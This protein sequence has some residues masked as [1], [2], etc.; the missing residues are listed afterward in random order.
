MWKK[1]DE[2]LAAQKAPEDAPVIMSHTVMGVPSLDSTQMAVQSILRQVEGLKSKINPAEIEKID[3]FIGS[4]LEGWPGLMNPREAEAFMNA[5]KTGTRASTMVQAFDKIGPQ[6]GGL[7]NVGAARFALMEPRLISA[8]QL[9]SGFSLGQL[10]RNL[11]G[12]MK[13][14]HETY[15]KS[16]PGSYIGGFRYQV[17]AE[18]MFPDWWK[19]GKAIDKNGNPVTLTNRQQALMTQMPVQKANQEWLDNIMNHFEQNKNKWG[20]Y[21]GGVTW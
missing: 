5:D 13:L 3:N 17:P 16:F 2:N 14:S 9:S 19:S 12:P 8:D 6:K 21:R 20:Y 7:P 4:K 18:L 15:D 11:I 1:I 10:D